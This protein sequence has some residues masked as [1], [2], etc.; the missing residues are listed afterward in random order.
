MLSEFI[1]QL[2]KE[3]ELK[4]PLGAEGQDAYSLLLDETTKITITDSSPGFQLSAKIGYLPTE[5]VEEFLSYMLRSNLFG[6]ATHNAVLG[7]D[8]TGANV[9]LNFHCKTKPSFRDFFDAFQDFVNTILF[10]QE[11]IKSHPSPNLS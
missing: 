5:K 7:L 2:Q 3:L 11:E 1:T 10:W 8:E 4:E 6:Q 9:T